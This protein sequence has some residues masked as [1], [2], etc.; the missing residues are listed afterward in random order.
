MGIPEEPST[1]LPPSYPNDISDIS[2]PFLPK[3]EAPVDSMLKDLATIILS[4]FLLAGWVAFVITYPKVS[5]LLPYVPDGH[6]GHYQALPAALVSLDG[7][8]AAAAPAPAVPEAAGGEDSAP[9]DAARHLP[10]PGRGRC[11]W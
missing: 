7:A 5:R 6:E 1:E 10:G 9:A 4:T 11:R 8:P 3:P 2:K